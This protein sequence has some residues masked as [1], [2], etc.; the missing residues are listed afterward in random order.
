M[1]NVMSGLADDATVTNFDEWGADWF[2]LTDL[3]DGV[4]HLLL[5]RG[6]FGLDTTRC[7]DIK[8]K[9]VSGCAADRRRAAGEP[10]ES[11]H[12]ILNEP[13]RALTRSARSMCTECV[14]TAG[15][16]KVLQ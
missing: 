14:R 12:T 4:V 9:W 8:V 1:S 15:T 5:R 7:G 2:R 10:T 3:R 6:E 13:G 16:P 11:G